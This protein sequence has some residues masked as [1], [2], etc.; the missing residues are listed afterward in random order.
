MENKIDDFLKEIA[1]SDELYNSSENINKN[2]VL[3]EL[4]NDVKQTNYWARKKC[5][6]LKYTVATTKIFKHKRKVQR[7][8]AQSRKINRNK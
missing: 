2:K 6:G 8:K 5:E 3:N 7:M 1:K 4:S